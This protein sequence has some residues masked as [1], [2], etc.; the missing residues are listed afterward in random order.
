MR[1]RCKF[2][3]MPR[4][5]VS[6]RCCCEFARALVG[7]TNAHTIVV[8][9]TVNSSQLKEVFA[10]SLA[11]RAAPVNVKVPSLQV[12]AADA[13]YGQAWGLL[14]CTASKKP[15]TPYTAQEALVR[16]TDALGLSSLKTAAPATAVGGGS[17]SGSVVVESSADEA[18]RVMT[19]DRLKAVEWA[20]RQLSACQACLPRFPLRSQLDRHLQEVCRTAEEQLARVGQQ[21]RKSEKYSPDS[22]SGDSGQATT[23]SM[24][25]RESLENEALALRALRQRLKAVQA[26]SKRD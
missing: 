10:L 19:K 12:I 20:V 3:V 22:G 23:M 16:C 1:L 13:R 9:L 5:D 24:K 11:K 8:W 21:L 17:D 18:W 25:D 6:G 2:T 26:G 4:V 15:R 14:M 7:S